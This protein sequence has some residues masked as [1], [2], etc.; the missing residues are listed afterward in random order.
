MQAAPPSNVVLPDRAADSALRSERCCIVAASNEPNPDKNQDHREF[1]RTDELIPTHSLVD[2]EL[3][4]FIDG[5]AETDSGKSPSEPTPSWFGR[6]PGAYDRTQAG[7]KCLIGNLFPVSDFPRQ[8][9]FLWR[10]SA[11]PGG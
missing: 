11:G 3:K 2:I 4:E 9:I 10:L 5:K 1:P 6:A 7:L 8:F